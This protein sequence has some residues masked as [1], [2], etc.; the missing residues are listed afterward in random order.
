MDTT[1]FTMQQMTKQWQLQI[2]PRRKAGQTMKGHGPNTAGDLE[3][4][5]EECVPVTPS[6]FEYCRAHRNVLKDFG[7]GAVAVP[8]TE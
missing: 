8:E 7:L 1:Q 2:F 5:I 4:C 3:N 6:L